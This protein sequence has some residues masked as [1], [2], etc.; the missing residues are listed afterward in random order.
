[1]IASDAI[2]KEEITAIADRGYYSGEEILACKL[3]GITTI[4]PKPQTSNNMAKGLFGKRDFRYIPEED[5]YRCPANER[6]IWRFT[7]ED[8]GL[9]QRCYWSSACGECKIKTQCTTS[10]QRRIK[11]W[12]HEEVLEEAQDRL[13]RMPDA[14]SIRRETVEHPFGTLKCW[15]GYTHFLTK[16]KARVS[17]EMSLHVLAYNLK[18][19]MN[20]LGTEKLIEGIRA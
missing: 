12:E 14:M 6:L 2:G 5:E 4:L 3:S 7:Y 20:L 10:S 1:V 15:M 19:V 8:R 16:T 18:R 17:T 9:L 13:D 11:R